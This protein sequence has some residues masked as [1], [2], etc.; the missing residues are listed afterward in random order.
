M[1]ALLR[2]VRVRNTCDGSAIS[3]LEARL[4]AY[5]SIN[6]Q[7]QALASG[8]IRLFPKTLNLSSLPEHLNLSPYSVRCEKVMPAERLCAVARKGSNALYT[9]VAKAIWDEYAGRNAIRR[10]IPV[11]LLASRYP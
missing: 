5:G 6:R 7:V 4:R 11:A 1:G 8:T 2:L 9:I 10:H 3:Q